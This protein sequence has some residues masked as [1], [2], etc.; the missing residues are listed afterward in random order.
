MGIFSMTL[1]D[2]RHTAEG[3]ELLREK[4]PYTGLNVFKEQMSRKQA[5]SSDYLCEVLNALDAGLTLAPNVIRDIQRPLRFCDPLHRKTLRELLIQNG[6]I[7]TGG[8]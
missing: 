8:V 5:L 4:S 6:V 7:P 3:Q 2:Y 1:Y